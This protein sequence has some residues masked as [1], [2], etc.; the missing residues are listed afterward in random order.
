MDGSL[1]SMIAKVEPQYFNAV[2]GQ[3][4]GM[5]TR[6]AALLNKIYCLADC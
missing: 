3:R 2:M 5:S 1:P 6:D 4:D